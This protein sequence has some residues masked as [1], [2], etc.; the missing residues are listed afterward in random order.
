MNNYAIFVDGSV[1]PQSGIGSGAFLLL[2]EEAL[3]Q[4]SNATINNNLSDQIQTQRFDNTSS[5]HLELEALLWALSLSPASASLTVYTDCQNII[6]LPQR[7]QRLQDKNYCNSAGEQLSLA[8]LY[9]LFY[10]QHTALNFTLTKLKGHKSQ[11]EKTTLDLLFS[12]VDKK[13]RTTCRKFNNT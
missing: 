12:L 5:T 6:R 13:A 8:H 9:K 7:K 2:K 4:L 11:S 10:Q 3:T 1:N